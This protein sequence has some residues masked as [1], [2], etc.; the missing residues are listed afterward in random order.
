MKIITEHVYPPIPTRNCD[1]SAVTVN[2]EVLAALV[3]HA[4]LSD[5]AAKSAIEAIARGQVPHLAIQY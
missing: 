1:W 3:E 2:N 5:A 4:G